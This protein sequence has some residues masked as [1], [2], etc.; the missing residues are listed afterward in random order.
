MKI[1]KLTENKIRITLRK[2]DFK[3]KSINL[4]EIILNDSD[5]HNLFLEILNRA[6]KEVN[7]DTNG[8]K[9]LIETFFSGNDI[10]IFTITKYIETIKKK[11]KKNL[12]TKRKLQTFNS[13]S[14]IYKFNEFE[15]FC[16]FCDFINNI[17]N[18]ELK[19]LFKICILYNYNNAYYLAFDNINLSHKSLNVFFSSLQEFS[20]LFRCNKNFKYKLK[21]HAE[22]IIKNNAISTGIK[23]FTYKNI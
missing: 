11:P 7:F 1:E 5:S 18:I 3:D 22:V 12:K 6:E 13:S 14:L 2:D 19:G 20:S 23:Y 8:H 21:E 15:D 16:A 9:L 10:C 4:Q 17:N